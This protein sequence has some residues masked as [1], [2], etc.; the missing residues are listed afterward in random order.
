MRESVVPDSV[1][2]NATFFAT[3]YC[4]RKG[5][6]NALARAGACTEGQ[7]DS[8]WLGFS[9]VRRRQKTLI[10]RDLTNLIGIVGLR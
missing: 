8:F 2:K 7:F 6:Q 10:L 5:L 4:N 1:G 9:Q 3:I